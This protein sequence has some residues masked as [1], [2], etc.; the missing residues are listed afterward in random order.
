MKKYTEPFEW[1]TFEELKREHAERTLLVK[2][3]VYGEDDT[4]SGAYLIA[5]ADSYNDNDL[6]ELSNQYQDKGGT[7]IEFS[8][9][10][11]RM[12]GE[13]PFCCDPELEIDNTTIMMEEA[14]KARLIYK[15]YKK[16][17]CK[18]KKSNQQ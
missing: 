9:I 2:D 18:W 14:A 4:S 13:F 10:V 1:K 8:D 15:Q 7:L 12:T 11:D 16:N 17:T 5:E 3:M 6:I